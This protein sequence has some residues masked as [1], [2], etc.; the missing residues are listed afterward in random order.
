MS[1][2][3][4]SNFYS[5]EHFFLILRSMWLHDITSLITNKRTELELFMVKFKRKFTTSIRFIGVFAIEQE[6]WHLLENRQ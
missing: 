5:D 1:S 4:L 6:R 2:T 3:I